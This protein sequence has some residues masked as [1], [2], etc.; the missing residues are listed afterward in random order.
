MTIGK[1]LWIII[2][3]KLFVM[4]LILKPFFFKSE[5]NEFSTQ[6]EK[7]SHVINELTKDIKN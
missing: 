1:T 5:L 6:Q 7:A 2:I 4:F 3:I